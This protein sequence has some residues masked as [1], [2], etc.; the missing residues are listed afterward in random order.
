MT[1]LLP[2]ETLRWRLL[3][4][5]REASLRVRWFYRLS[6]ASGAWARDDYLNLRPIWKWVLRKLPS[7]PGRP[8]QLESVPLP[9]RRKEP[10][11]SPPNE[12]RLAST[13]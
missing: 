7:A 2:P 5:G 6:S 13:D 12:T 11:K 10:L 4:H 8:L 3:L 9:I 1:F